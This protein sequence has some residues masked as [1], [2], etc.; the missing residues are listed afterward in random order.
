MDTTSMTSNFQFPKLD[1]FD[2]RLRTTFY[3]QLLHHIRDVV[4]NRFLADEQLLGNVASRF[5]LYKQFEHFAFPN[6]E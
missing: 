3:I 1:Q 6:R 2:D 5:V 4:A